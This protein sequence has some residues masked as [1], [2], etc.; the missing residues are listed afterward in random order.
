MTTDPS[1]SMV[2]TAPSSNASLGAL[3]EL[4]GTWV[5]TGFVLVARPDFQNRK[6]FFLQVNSTVENLEFTDIGGNIPNRGSEQSDITLHGLSYQQRISDDTTHNVLHLENGAWISIPQTMD[7][8]EPATVVRQSSIP[9]GVSFLAQSTLLKHINDRPTIDAV[10]SLP[11][12]DLTIPGLNTSAQNILS[13]PAYIAPYLNTPL[14]A[15]SFSTLDAKAV[16]QNPTLILLEAIKD[17]NITDTV[18]IQ[19]STSAVQ[20]STGTLNTPFLVRNASA[21]QVDA[22]FWIETVQPIG[23]APFMQ[24]Q[25]VQRAILDFPAEPNG[26]IIHWPHISVATLIK[27]SSWSTD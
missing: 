16:I 4:P 6:P 23:A 18:V 8:E 15:G 13:D 9:L 20:G 14:P 24:L 7:P 3:T 12:T 27:Q 1:S 26:T 10:N 2:V 21:V 17:Q 25:Y 22:I 5:G 19:I 11:F